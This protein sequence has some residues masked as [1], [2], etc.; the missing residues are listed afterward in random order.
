MENIPEV[1]SINSTVKNSQHQYLKAYAEADILK[2]GRMFLNSVAV[3]PTSC[4]QQE[5]D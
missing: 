4:R 5:V 1:N 3:S 2:C